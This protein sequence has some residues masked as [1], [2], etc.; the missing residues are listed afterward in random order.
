MTTTTATAFRS[1]GSGIT[2]MRPLF[3]ASVA[4]S[5]VAASAVA[6]AAVTAGA[7]PAYA[8][9]V[10]GL[11]A[12]GILLSGTFVVNAV[13]G[14]MPS[15]SLMVAMLTYLLQVVM[16]GVAFLALST[17]PL[18][19]TAQNRG[20]LSGTVIACTA[21]WLI[22]QMWSSTHARIPVYDLEEPAASHAKGGVQP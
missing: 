6:L 13:A 17:S 7:D 15:M 4:V 3:G 8:A 1:Q 16:M 14:L 19:E 22:A 21:A 5:V 12:V 9:L 20:W 10:G 2:G 18:A 11:M